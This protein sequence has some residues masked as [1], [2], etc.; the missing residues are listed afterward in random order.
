MSITMA[1]NVRYTASH[2]MTTWA[3]MSVIHKAIRYVRLV[4]ITTKLIALHVSR[5]TQL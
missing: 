2:E 5:E 1:D 4:I 3:T